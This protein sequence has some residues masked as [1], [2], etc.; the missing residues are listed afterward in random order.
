MVYHK[1]LIVF[2]Y[3]SI[4]IRPTGH[5]IDQPHKILPKICNFT[6]KFSKNCMVTSLIT[7]N[8]VKKPGISNSD[9]LFMIF[10]IGAFSI[11]LKF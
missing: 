7:A 10:E 4:N 3:S 9:M 8:E 5:E 11:D 6:L 2:S 1:V